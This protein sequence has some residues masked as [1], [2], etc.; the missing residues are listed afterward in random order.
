MSAEPSDGGGFRSLADLVT[1]LEQLRWE[2][3]EKDR[4]IRVAVAALEEALSVG[5]A[6]P[7]S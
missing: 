7:P 4:C 6:S 2:V 5:G 3:G 1:E